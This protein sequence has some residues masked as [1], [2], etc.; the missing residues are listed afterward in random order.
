MAKSS[1]ELTRELQGTRLRWSL[2][3]SVREPPSPSAFLSAVHPSPSAPH[4]SRFQG[5]PLPLHPS[6]GHR[7]P[8]SILRCPL[9]SPFRTYLSQSLPSRSSVTGAVPSR[10]LGLTLSYPGPSLGEASS[11]AAG[12][13]PFPRRAG[14]GPPRRV[15]EAAPGPDRLWAQHP[16]S[17]RPRP[18]TGSKE[19]LKKPGCAQASGGKDGSQG[20][21]LGL[22]LKPGTGSL[23]LT[24]NNPHTSLPP[25]LY[26]TPTP[27]GLSCLP[28]PQ[29]VPNQDRPPSTA[30]TLTPRGGSTG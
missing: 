2:G 23:Q 22:E 26:P 14:P 21:G 11:L 28:G 12:E 8:Q 29:T 10:S 1:A 27:Q 19:P 3:R 25:A 15:M 16:P 30:T 17:S 20:R 6:S 4:A 13:S 9:A 18:G 24:Y 5:S 7:C